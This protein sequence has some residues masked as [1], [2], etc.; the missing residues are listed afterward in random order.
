MSRAKRRRLAKAGATLMVA[1]AEGGANN[2]FV[3][4]MVRQLLE[5]A[6]KGGIRKVV[7]HLGNGSEGVGLAVALQRL[8]EGGDGHGVEAAISLLGDDA[9]SPGDAA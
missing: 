2:Q 5:Q 1:L 7:P 3:L 6:R 8:A 4:S 9:T